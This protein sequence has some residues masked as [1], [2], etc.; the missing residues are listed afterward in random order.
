M[1][2]AT[3]LTQGRVQLHYAIQFMAATNMA[4]A[5]PQPDGSQV[6]IHW[7]L[8]ISG[9]I[10]QLLAGDP[11]FYLALEPDTLTSLILNQQLQPLATL[12]LN[13]MTM[14]AALEWHKTEL[15]KLGVTTDA[16]K[17]LDYPEDF[18]DHPLAQ[19]A[20]F[21]VEDEDS[22]RTLAAYYAHTQPL[23]QAIVQSQTGAS[24]IYI[25]PHHFDMATLITVSG[26]GED[27]QTI[28]VGLSPGDG[29]YDQPYWYV[30]PWPYPSADKLPELSLGH[31]HTE[32]WV[33]AILTAAE[34]GDP[35]L[36]QTQ[37]TLET[38]L[39]KAVSS[40]HALFA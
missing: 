36:K 6:T 16:I 38:F 40:C 12:Q 4:L 27:T 8:Q 7:N 17:F 29:S 13:G 14:A 9:F 24:P 25:W 11:P 32:G 33:A 18:P 15:A 3:Q 21:T 19:G 35:V 26:S 30:S 28:G 22:R 5:T 31:W 1:K 34:I 10:G 2:E 37:P 39:S 20:V 23:L